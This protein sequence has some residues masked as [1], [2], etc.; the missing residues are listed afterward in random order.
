MNSFMFG[1]LP[2]LISA[3]LPVPI[4]VNGGV[5]SGARG[6]AVDDEMIDIVELI[7]VTV[8][9]NGSPL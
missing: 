6:A 1:V 4:S 7:A 5:S 3:T 2:L 8:R 9:I